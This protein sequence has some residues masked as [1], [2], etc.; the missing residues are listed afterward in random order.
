LDGQTLTVVQQAAVDSGDFGLTRSSS[1][2][3]SMR[4][5]SQ[6]EHSGIIWQ[7]VIASIEQALAINLV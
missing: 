1:H 6:V 5:V 7:P 2:P 3:A 4:R